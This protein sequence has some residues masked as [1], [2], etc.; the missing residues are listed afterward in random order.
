[1]WRL[2]RLLT[3]LFIAFHSLCMNNTENN[4]D[5]NTTNHFEALRVDLAPEFDE[6]QTVAAHQRPRRPSCCGGAS[7]QARRPPE[8][9]RNRAA[10]P[11]VKI[12]FSCPQVA[13]EDHEET[14]LTWDRSP[15]PQPARLCVG[16]DCDLAVLSPGCKQL[17]HYVQHTWTAR[18]LCRTVHTWTWIYRTLC[19]LRRPETARAR[20]VLNHRERVG[21]VVRRWKLLLQSD[22]GS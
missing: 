22:F 14:S 21:F 16:L 11:S 5:G 3:Y 2:K 18:S 7:A 9:H 20:W 1:M 6:R 12:M 13:D 8:V 19:R 4:N 15:Y 17:Q 10:R